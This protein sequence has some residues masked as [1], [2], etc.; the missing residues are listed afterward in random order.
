MGKIIKG[1]H[2]ALNGAKASVKLVPKM[3]SKIPFNQIFRT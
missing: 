1:S 2:Q 3:K